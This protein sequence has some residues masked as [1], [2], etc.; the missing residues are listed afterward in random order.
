MVQSHELNHA[1]DDLITGLQPSFDNI[2]DRVRDLESQ[3]GQALLANLVPNGGF[4]LW[5]YGV[6][7]FTTHGASINAAFTSR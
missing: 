2:L 3:D 1:L 6:G 5:E 7:P 4:D